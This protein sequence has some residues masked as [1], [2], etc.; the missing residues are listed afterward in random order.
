[1][2]EKAARQV[3]GFTM[4]LLDFVMWLAAAAA[5]PWGILNKNYFVGWGG[6]ALAV[7]ALVIAT[8][9]MIV[10]PNQ[11]RV[12]TFLGRYLGTVRRNGFS[13]TY[14]LTLRKSLSLRIQNFDS[15]TLKV[16]DAVGNP[17]E[18]AAVIVWRVVDTAKAAFEVEDYQEFVKIQTETAVR[19]MTSE[20]P[21]DSY[22]PGQHSLRANADE[23]MASLHGELQ[24]QLQTAGVEVI[25]TQLRRLAYAPEIAA[26]MLR[27]QQ[28]DAVVAARQRIVE[29]AVGM[30]DE[31][32]TMLAAKDIVELDDQRKAAMVSNLLVVLCSEHHAQPI[33]NT[34][35]LYQ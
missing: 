23:V 29:G 22:E 17:I 31:A 10:A 21:Y 25:R 1:M 6:A 14:P 28:A 33:V 35:T 26:D 5:I 12:V 19:H 27:R 24:Q 16:N 7:V 34:G 11:S 15:Q 20:Y 3:S 2:R 13:W 18:V 8:G 30:V 9:F 4:L 32:L